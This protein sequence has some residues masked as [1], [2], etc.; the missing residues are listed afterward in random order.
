MGKRTLESIAATLV[1]ILIITGVVY[2]PVKLIDWR[3]KNL[4]SLMI[5]DSCRR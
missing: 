3:M 2:I 5:K 1:M 4:I